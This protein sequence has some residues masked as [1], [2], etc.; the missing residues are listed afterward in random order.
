MRVLSGSNFK[1]LSSG[2]EF[3]LGEATFRS[4]S[5]LLPATIKSSAYLVVKNSFPRC[6]SKPFNDRLANHGETGL[7]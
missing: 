5:G 2:K 6:F 4:S 3:I 7:S 1:P